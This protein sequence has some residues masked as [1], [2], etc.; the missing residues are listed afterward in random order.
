MWRMATRAIAQYCVG[1]FYFWANDF[2]ESHQSCP[3]ESST[4]QGK[5]ES[6]GHLSFSTTAECVTS[7][8]LLSTNIL[9]LWYNMATGHA[10]LL[11]SAAQQLL[12]KSRSWHTQKNEHHLVSLFFGAAAETLIDWLTSTLHNFR[13]EKTGGG[14]TKILEVYEY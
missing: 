9:R 5:T 13:Y 4:V 14:G 10:P 8:G 6:S 7:G 1:V 11:L 2:L 12:S 3:L